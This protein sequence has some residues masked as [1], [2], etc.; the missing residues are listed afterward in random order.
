M[1]NDHYFSYDQQ[2]DNEW[3]SG[4]NYGEFAL[5]FAAA[6]GEEQICHLLLGCHSRRIERMIELC[7]DDKGPL[8]RNIGDKIF[9]L[10]EVRL[11]AAC[12]MRLCKR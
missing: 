5:S 11:S 10:K 8:A 4:C 3:Y 7:R 1:H 12:S 9:S 2:D 6:V